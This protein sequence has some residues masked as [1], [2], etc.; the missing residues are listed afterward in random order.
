VHYIICK[1]ISP[2]TETNIAEAVLPPQVGDEEETYSTEEEITSE[3]QIVTNTT[4]VSPV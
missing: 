4:E 1:Y 3:K 2:P